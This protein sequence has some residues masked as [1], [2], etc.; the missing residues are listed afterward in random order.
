MGAAL[1]SCAEWIYSGVPTSREP[2]RPDHFQHLRSHYGGSACKRDERKHKKE[3]ERQ[4]KT[5]NV[6]EDIEMED[7]EPRTPS[8][9]I[10]V[11]NGCTG[12]LVRM[13]CHEGCG[14]GATLVGFSADCKQT[15]VNGGCCSACRKIP[16]EV[17]MLVWLADDTQ[18][19]TN[20]FYLT[21]V[22]KTDLLR[23]RTEEVRQFRVK[24]LNVSRK[25]STAL[26]KISDYK[27]FVNAIA[28][29]DVPR[30]RNL[31][32][33][34]L[35]HGAS[36]SQIIRTMQMAVDGVYR[37]RPTICQ[38]TL[39]MA[40]LIFRLGGRKLLYA[41]NQT[42]DIPSLRTLRNNMQFT[43][44]M[45]TVGWIN[46]T[47][48]STISRSLQIDEVAIEERVAHSCYGLLGFCWCHSMNAKLRLDAF[49]DALDLSKMVK[50][51]E[52]HMG[53]EMTVVAARLF[54]RPA[55]LPDSCAPYL[56]IDRPRGVEDH[57]PDCYRGLEPVR[58]KHR[59]PCLVIRYRRRCE[60]AQ[61]GFDEFCKTKLAVTS[62]C[63]PRLR[64]CTSLS[65]FVLNYALVEGSFSGT[66]VSST[67]MSSSG[68]YRLPG[69]TEASVQRLL[70]PDD[71]QDVSRPVE[72]MEKIVDIGGAGFEASDPE[73]NSGG[74]TW[75]CGTGQWDLP[76]VKSNG[77]FPY[78]FSDG[79]HVLLCKPATDQ[80]VLHLQDKT[81]HD[82][83]LC[84]ENKI[85]NWRVH[86]GTHLYRFQRGLNDELL[87]GV[88]HNFSDTLSSAYT[89]FSWN[90][91]M[92][93]ASA[94]GV[95]LQSAPV[96]LTRTQTTFN[97]VS[98]CPR[99]SEVSLRV[100][101]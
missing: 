47:I 70:Y 56:Q 25:L 35:N 71:P 88:R 83:H 22:Q 29:Q 19:Q 20:F 85:A 78:T 26:R 45:P 82:C 43:R 96:S 38:Q 14:T 80:L 30:L 17:A 31:V 28:E 32:N 66:D 44:V 84:G 54:W 40:L 72:L 50:D 3:L 81:N 52:V 91:E 41:V 86:T 97:V 37:P 10:T 27:R 100:C 5:L 36:V 76:S 49:Q 89:S 95:V 92:L 59:W 2:S 75:R 11:V 62:R 61:A 34:G 16:A 12:V 67:P 53:S 9:P 58:K 69:Q 42:L 57:L 90:T 63:T 87:T 21:D 39:N 23:K 101:R 4:K 74:K 55:S 68:S 99:Y 48:S 51:G 64:V 7:I 18:P 77:G 13:A 6:D 15:G 24:A 73:V 1:P 60:T 46:G 98:N 8:P 94:D 79:T 93:A 33:V 65:V